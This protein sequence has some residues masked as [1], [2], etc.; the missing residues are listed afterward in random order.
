[1]RWRGSEFAVARTRDLKIPGR[2]NVCNA[3]TASLAA[4]ALGV[5]PWYV[6]EA[7]KRFGGL[8]HRLEMVAEAPGNVRFFNDSIATTPESAICAME[9]F[10][11]PITL[12][13]GG[14]DKGVSFDSFARAAVRRARRVILMGATA[15]KIEAALSR[16]SAEYGRGPQVLRAA[17]LRQACAWAV[18]GAVEG[19]TILLSPACASFDQFRNFEERGELFRALATRVALGSRAADASDR[20]R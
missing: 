3:L 6:S 7:L 16:A 13:A 10:P 5:E 11:P 18:E 20:H 4:V 12:I 1:V 2:H 15:D 17:D 14:S 9:S 19:E 8:P